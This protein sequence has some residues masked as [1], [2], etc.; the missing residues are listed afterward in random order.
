MPGRSGKLTNE[1]LHSR[2][3]RLVLAEGEQNDN[4]FMVIFRE[5]QSCF[6]SGFGHADFV[7]E[8][9]GKYTI[10]RTLAKSYTLNYL[11]KIGRANANL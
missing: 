3:P 8:S 1:A 5:G 10:F 7:M 2:G 9:A 11:L 6:S 4:R